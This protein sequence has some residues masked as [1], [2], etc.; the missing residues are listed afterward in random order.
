MKT[1]YSNSELQWHLQNNVLPKLSNA[2]I[3]GI[4]NTVDSF[5]TGKLKI[6]SEVKEGAGVTVGEMFEDLRIEVE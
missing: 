3:T 1:T 5:N 4:L 2:A 6:D